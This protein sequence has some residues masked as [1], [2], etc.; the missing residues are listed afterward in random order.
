MDASVAV[1][2]ET[3]VVVVDEEAVSVV[4]VVLAVEGSVVGGVLR[5]DRHLDRPRVNT[6]LDEE[7]EGLLLPFVFATSMYRR[8]GKIATLHG[9]SFA[10]I[11]LY[12]KEV[13][14][15]II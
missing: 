7:E 1:A 4:E 15:M 9:F 6:D 10:S 13:F 2:A 12:E 5:G 14:C 11:V 3:E 8:R